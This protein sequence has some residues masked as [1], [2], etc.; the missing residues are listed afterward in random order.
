MSAQNRQISLRI[1]MFLRAIAPSLRGN[2]NAIGLWADL[3]ATDLLQNTSD[4][5]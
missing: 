2:K 5:S 1:P 3:L 4:N